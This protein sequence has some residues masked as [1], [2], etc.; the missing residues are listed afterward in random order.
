MN[1]VLIIDDEEGVRRALHKALSKEDY[2]IFL[3]S[4][5]QAAIDLV[6]DRPDDIAIVI[7]DYKM[8][9]IDGLQ[10]LIAIGNLNPD[11][12][13]IMLTGYATL[14]SAIAATNEGLDGFLTKPFDNMELR[15]K[16]REYFV[17]KR[18]KQ[19][20]SPQVLREL[21]ERPSQL[22]PRNCIVSV[23]FVD[24]RGFTALTGRHEPQAWAAFL[25]HNYFGPMGEIIFRNHGTLDKHIGDC[26]M[27]IYGAPS[28]AEDDARRAIRSALEMRDQ[29]TAINAA[30]D[31]AHQL[32][33]G[34]GVHTGEVVAGMFGSARKR[35]YTTLGQTVNLAN[36]LQKIAAP[37]QIVIT[38]ATRDAVGDGLRVDALPPL[39]VRGI[40]DNVPLYTVL[41]LS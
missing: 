17:R 39:A 40:S 3:A 10:T 13:R 2:Q 4:D 41:S 26:I 19:F 27:A 5:G 24:I 23:L 20:V 6:T 1:G 16:V 33:I 35:E 30:A 11:I 31:P 37:G 15:A 38:Q 29:M 12:T 32:P 21:Q 9:G 22:L 7:S 28:S 34:I 25:S 8:P 36:R 14:D 18:L